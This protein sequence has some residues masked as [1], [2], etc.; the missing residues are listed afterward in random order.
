MRLTQALAFSTALLV[1]VG[2]AHATAPPTSP[3][4]APESSAAETSAAPETSLAPA[5]EPVS[6]GGVTVTIVGVHP[7]DPANAVVVVAEVVTEIELSGS[8]PAI[9]VT[10]SGQ[11]VQSDAFFAIASTVFPGVTKLVAWS[12]GTSE[13]EGIVYW[14]V[15]G[16]DGTPIEFQLQTS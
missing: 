6:H 3:P 4:S 5:G 9:Y 10:T 7:S 15:I 8:L 16:A 11:Q 2:V 1:A 14:T 12:F 13:V